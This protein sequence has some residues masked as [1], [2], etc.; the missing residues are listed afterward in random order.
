MTSI[1]AA[2][3][4]HCKLSRKGLTSDTVQ[5][6]FRLFVNAEMVD[7]SHNQISFLRSDLLPPSIITLD[8]SHNLF[9]RI[10]GLDRLTNMTHLNL[11]YP[12]T[13]AH[14]HTTP[15]PDMASI[16]KLILYPCRCNL[17]QSTW[18]LL[19]CTQLKVRTHPPKNYKREIINR[20]SNTIVDVTQTTKV[21]VNMKKH[22]RSGFGPEW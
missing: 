4:K 8:L 17:L 12:H 6:A 14:T 19:S 11:R 18:G 9:T 5:K 3:I 16:T 10:I 15:T 1:S 20:K 21:P 7:V 22:T 13:H 2:D